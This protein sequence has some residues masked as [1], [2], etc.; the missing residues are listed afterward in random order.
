MGLF[1]FFGINREA[2]SIKM[3]LT[4]TH[5]HTHIHM[6]THTLSLSIYKVYV[7]ITV[8]PCLTLCIVTEIQIGRYS[9]TY[10]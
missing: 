3:L 7:C 2:Q 9:H 4:H 6:H 1:G 10:T 8:Y 5:T